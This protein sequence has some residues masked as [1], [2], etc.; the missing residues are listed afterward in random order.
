MV[1]MESDGDVECGHCGETGHGDCAA[2]IARLRAELTRLTTAERLE[3]PA[4][5]PQ[6]QPWDVIEVTTVED[7]ARGVR[8]YLR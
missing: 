1:E 2:E 5:A 4:D 8:R 6:P 3:L 7:L